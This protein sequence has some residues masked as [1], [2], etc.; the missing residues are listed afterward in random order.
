MIGESDF[1]W[2]DDL[3][4]CAC[5]CVCELKGKCKRVACHERNVTHLTSRAQGSVNVTYL[6]HIYFGICR[7]RIVL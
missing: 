4:S 1:S 2:M 3:P 6:C 7:F 5:V